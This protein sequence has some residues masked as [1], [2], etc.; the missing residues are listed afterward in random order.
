MLDRKTAD[1][2]TAH[3]RLSVGAPV[4]IVD[5]GSNSVRLVA[6]EGLTRSP[7]PIYNEKVLCGLGRGVAT[8]GNLAPEG[9]ERALAALSRYRKLCDVMGVGDVV[10]IATAAARD[11][12][13]G[14]EF[15]RAATA[16]I[17][18]EPKLLSGKREAELSGLGVISGIHQPNGVV[19]D[20][21]GGSLELI[22]V[23]DARLGKGTTLP[24]GGLTLMDASGKSARQAL[25][26]V[27]E[28][29]AEAPPVA[30]LRGRDFYAVGGTWRAFARLHMRQRNYPLQIMHGYTIPASDAADFAE[31]LARVDSDALDA[32]TSV[33]SPR[34]PL[35]AYGAVVL[36]EI[37]R[38]AKPRDIVF[39]AAG[40]R[41][42]LL[43]ERLAP[44]LQ[45]QDPL[46]AAAEQF[47]TLRSRNPQHAIELADWVEAFWR[48]AK[49]GDWDDEA[50]LRRAACLL[51]DIAWRAHPD[52]RGAQAFDL[53]VNAAALGV[54]HPGRA[55]VAL[56]NAVRHDGLSETTSPQL[57]A[58]VPARM[59]DH[60][61]ILG[62]AMRVAYALSA[63]MPGMLTRVP[64]TAGK[65]DVTVTLPRDLR[66]LRSE[67]LS[68]RLRQL[69]R[70][71]GREPKTEIEA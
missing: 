66:E 20:L 43:F 15:L 1:P 11:A 32:I 6:Y 2:D 41:E 24:L 52:Y 17:G 58:L 18:Q 40:V 33:A 5:I 44:A 70:L 55:F 37:I 46:L 22:D 63:A 13:N 3:G 8:T 67:R 56:A 60:A 62:A 61:R 7:T 65:K 57:R 53:I 34:R 49:L 36:Q 42:G 14:A 39:S 31:L 23:H 16:M 45:L 54:D 64:M 25:K 27:R 50:R 59:Q 12:G 10:A 26:I 21:G 9:M 71:I 69:A 68:N 47:N 48:T 4:A 35:L 51:A 38:R 19:G 28:A 29:I 30:D